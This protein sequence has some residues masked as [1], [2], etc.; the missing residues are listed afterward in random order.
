MRALIL[1]WT[2]WSRHSDDQKVNYQSIHGN[3]L[4]SP[5]TDLHAPHQLSLVSAASHVA[6]LTSKIYKYFL[7][8]PQLT[9]SNS[10]L[11]WMKILH[12]LRWNL[13]KQ[14]NPGNVKFSRAKCVRIASL[15]YHTLVDQTWLILLNWLRCIIPQNTECETARLPQELAIGSWERWEWDTG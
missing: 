14:I 6:I 12:L 11:T 13:Q 8:N 9:K 7:K 5:V 3:Q 15:N 10:S 4:S 2:S 1:T